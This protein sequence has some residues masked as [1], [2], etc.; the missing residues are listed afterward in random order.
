M[1]PGGEALQRGEMRTAT[2][3]E[4]RYDEMESHSDDSPI[5]TVYIIGLDIFDNK[6]FKIGFTT[7]TVEERISGLQTGCPF[8]IKKI[9]AIKSKKCFEELF[10][11]ALESAVVMGEWF[12]FEKDDLLRV[13]KS[14]DENAL[15]FVDDKFIQP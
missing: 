10:H 7:K 1:R 13:L 11:R 9:A 4:K 2:R 15:L 3:W 8:K 14:L 5:G 6:V 12:R